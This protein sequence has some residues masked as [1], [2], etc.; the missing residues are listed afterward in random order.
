M[1]RWKFC[2]ANGGWWLVIN[3]LEQFAEYKDKTS[4]KYGQAIV[5]EALD[6]KDGKYRQLFMAAETIAKRDGTSIMQGM[7]TLVSGMTATQLSYLENGEELWFN[8]LGGYNLGLK[9]IEATVVLDKLIF[10]HYTEKDI[11][12]STWGDNGRHYYA[13]VGEIEVKEVVDGEV[14]M[15]WNTRDEAYQKALNYCSI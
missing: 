5:D 12:I 8:E 14:V 2:K 13:K 9:D 1:S 10:P 6:K 7:S 15:K 11:R 4:S 3:N